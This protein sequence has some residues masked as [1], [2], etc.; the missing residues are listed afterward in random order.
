MYGYFLHRPLLPEVPLQQPREGLAVTGFVAGHFVHGVM[1]GVQVQGLGALGQVG[2]AGG[3]A[4]LG[5]HAHLQV[6]LGA[7]GQHLAQQLGELGG[8]LGLFKR[9][10]L[11]VF[12]DLGIALAII[13]WLQSPSAVIVKPKKRKF[14]IVS[15]SSPS[16]CHE[17]MGLDTMV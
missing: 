12:A 8:V 4:V 14:V 1:D 9:G 15:T 3:G 16:I 11:P 10:G 2:L 6:L 17:V 7:V 13:S 5:L